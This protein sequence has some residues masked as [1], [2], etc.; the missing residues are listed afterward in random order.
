MDR[1]EDQKL[2]IGTRGT[3]DGAAAAV[4]LG[5]GAAVAVGLGVG[6]AAAEGSAVAAGLPAVA[7]ETFEDRAPDATT[8]APMTS[9]VP[10]KISVRG[11]RR[12][13]FGILIGD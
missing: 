6:A 12:R 4:G 9:A 2:T 7:C 3:S 10:T 11:G 8:T 13:K 1:C 5:V